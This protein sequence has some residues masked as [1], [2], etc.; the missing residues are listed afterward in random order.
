MLTRVPALPRALGLAGILPQ[1]ACLAAILLGP[2]EWRYAALAIGAG[3]AGLILSFLGGM[4]WGIAAARDATGA[5]PP[6]WIWF[7]AVVPSL[8]ALGAYL[9][10]VFG[11]P[12]PGPSLVLIGSAIIVSLLVDLAVRPLAPRWWMALRVPL[13]LGLGTLTILLAL[14]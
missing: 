14:A 9:P 6:A 12:W 1:A 7:A 8:I 11:Y 10:W 2:P 3:Y 5:P 4:W 13:S